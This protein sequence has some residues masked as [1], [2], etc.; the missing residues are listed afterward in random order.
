VEEATDLRE[1]A[2]RRVRGGV[3]TDADEL[4]KMAEVDRSGVGLGATVG[5]VERVLWRE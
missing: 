5:H 1:L 4:I 3:E 2:M